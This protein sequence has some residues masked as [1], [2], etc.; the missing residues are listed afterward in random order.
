MLKVRDLRAGYGKSEVLRGISFDVKQGEIVT[1]VGANGAGKTTTLRTLCGIVRATAGSIELDGVALSARQPHEIVELGVTMIPEGRQLFPFLTVE[2]NL[3]MGAFKKSARDTYPQKLEELLVLFP[4]VKERLKQLAVSLSGGE[5][6]MVAIARGMMAGP[7]LL[8]FDEP[9]LG[10]SPLLVEQM[11]EIVRK[12][13][14]QGTT[15]LLVEQNVFHT[16]QLADRGYVLE[17]GEVVLSGTGKDLL[18]NPHIRK[19]YL[20]H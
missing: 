11:F 15:V 19:A 17:N 4:R 18:V 6:Q 16:L 3:R 2:E 7:R 20:G 1:I 10:L 12:V 14:D 8:I 13:A 5:Q 9:S